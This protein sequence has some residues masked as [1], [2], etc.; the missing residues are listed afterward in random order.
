[1]ADTTQQAIRPIS[2][3][4]IANNDLASLIQFSWQVAPATV[5][6]EFAKYGVP[7]NNQDDVD[8]LVDMWQKG[9]DKSGLL[10]DKN[11]APMPFD[12]QKV[13][14]NVEVTFQE[15]NRSNIKWVD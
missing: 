8:T 3:S 2:R 12:T 4:G 7:I 9:L 14:A 5:T 15:L 6:K 1:M 10:K 11:G 13:M